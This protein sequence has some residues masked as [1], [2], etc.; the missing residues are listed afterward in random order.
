[1]ATETDKIKDVVNQ[2]W[3]KYDTNNLGLL[4][5]EETKNLAQETLN[6]LGNTEKIIDKDFDEL[7]NL[8]DKDSSGE[9]KQDDFTSLIE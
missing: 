8:F 5:K 2:L 6:K 1:M 4:K 3:D 7:F 9:V